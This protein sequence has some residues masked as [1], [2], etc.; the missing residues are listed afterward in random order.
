MAHHRLGAGWIALHIGAMTKT[1]RTTAA[2]TLLGSHPII[3]FIATR[4]AA[5]AK[6]FYRD[7]L[8]LRLVAEDPFA[9]A[10]D[11]NGTMLRVTPVRRLVTQKH[12]VLGWSVPD[13]DAS[14]KALRSVGV[15]LQRYEGMQQDAVGIWSSPSGA[16]V[17]WFKDPDGNTLSITEL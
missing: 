7:T 10:F 9:L 12:T 13:I 3:A 6:T 11:A 14:A 17:A 15:E 2:G 5:R 8:G 1:R 4:D 16:R